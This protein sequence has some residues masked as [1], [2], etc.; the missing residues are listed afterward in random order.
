VNLF[1]AK[2][3]FVF[4]QDDSGD[5]QLLLIEQ[6]AEGKNAFACDPTGA[7]F[8]AL[9]CNFTPICFLRS[10]PLTRDD[11]GVQRVD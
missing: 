8:D 3:S 9:N 4:R 11:A 7:G 10:C 5:Q 2:V 6:E 1:A